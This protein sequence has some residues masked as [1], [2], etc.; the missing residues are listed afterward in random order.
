MYTPTKNKLV[1]DLTFEVGKSDSMLLTGHNGAGK[2]SVFRCLAGL[3]SIPKGTIQKPRGDG[4]L[5]LAGTVFYLPQKPYNVLGTLADQLTYP[6]QSD[7]RCVGATC[8]VDF[9]YALRRA[10]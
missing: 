5:G 4:G 8:P 3:W 6:A 9:H 10:Q 1:H 2:S 7:G